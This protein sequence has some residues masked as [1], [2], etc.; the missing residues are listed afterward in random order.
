M[1]LTRR[2]ITDIGIN[3]TMFDTEVWIRSASIEVVKHTKTESLDLAHSSQSPL[4]ISS[5]AGKCT[6]DWPAWEMNWQ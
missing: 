6:Y 4:P 5:L 1:F 2:K 3:N